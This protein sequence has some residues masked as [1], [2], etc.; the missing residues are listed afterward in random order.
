MAGL[1]KIIG[2]ISSTSDSLVQ[3]LLRKAEEQAAAIRE[4]AEKEA[5]NATAKI[6][7]E[8]DA[9]LA[10]VGSRAK[11]AAALAKR[12]LLL[13]KKQDLISEFTMKAKQKFAELPD[14]AYFE[15]I[16]K[17]IQKN[18]LPRA[19]EVIFCKKDLDRLP[20]DFAIRVQR[21]ADMKGGKLGI[22]KDSRDM[23]GGFVLLY[24]GMELNCSL[25]ALFDTNKEMLQDKIQA[26][27][28]S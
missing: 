18:A 19:G 27:L 8:S 22:S 20:I 21:V 9:R 11:S 12:Q 28:F 13:Q 4:D 2:E 17:L 6:F 7:R 24:E 23:N 26:M 25:D 1:D 10:D 16:E 15:A 3:D 14:N 5:A